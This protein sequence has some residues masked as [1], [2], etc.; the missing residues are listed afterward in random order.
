[1]FKL[2]QL[3]KQDETVKRYLAAPLVRSRLS[4]LCHR[5]EHGT[6]PSTLR[7][8]TAFQVNMVRYLELWNSER[9]AR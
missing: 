9:K 6:K 8:I 2:K 1:M 4:Y 3:F 7:H 5:A